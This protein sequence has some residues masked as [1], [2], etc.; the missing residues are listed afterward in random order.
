MKAPENRTIDVDVRDL[1]TR[2]R[3]VQGYAAVYGALSEDLGG[4]REKIAPGAFADVLDAD[5]RALLNHDPDQLLGRTKSG[6]LRLAEDPRGLRFE[7]DLP[8][9]P[10]GENV[11]AAVARQDLDG[12][13]FRF[14]VG[15]ESWDGDVRTVETVAEL[16]DV[17]LATHPAYPE[18]SVELRTRPQATDSERTDSPMNETITDE[19]PEV[20]EEAEERTAPALTTATLDKIS[21]TR[22]TSEKVTEAMLAVRP[23]ES[24]ALSN[25]DDLV[26]TELS[27]FLFDRLRES[28]TALA[29]GVQ[30]IQT[31]KAEVSFPRLVSDVAPSWF[32]E[33]DEITA[34]DPAFDTITAI[35][36]KLAARV[37]MSNEVIDDASPSVVE[38][39]QANLI[40]RLA[41]GLDDGILQGDGTGNAPVGLTNVDDTLGETAVGSINLDVIADGI[42]AIRAANANPGAIIL[43][44][45]LWTALQKLKDASDDRP[46][47][48]PDP[49]SGTRPSL[50]GVPVYASGVLADDEGESN[51]L[52]F[53]PSE[54]YL[55]RRSEVSVELDRSRLFDRDQSELR[56][57]LR[58]DLIVPN[59][60]AVWVGAGVTA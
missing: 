59:P 32:A 9:S 11:R 4:F 44:P 46:L 30:V 2:G 24:R 16:H 55:V 53:D 57:R 51:V 25:A 36:K 26:T 19:A 23:G 39:A 33:A 31:D 7:L 29:S 45:E 37:V 5:V 60:S 54:V 21:E 13:S 6:T 1:D 43:R 58:A 42:G 50:F 28:S 56:G 17:T 18:T 35:P 41:L 48:Q 15:S 3:T 52:V 12:A 47:L 22:S 20:V 49:T 14:L 38:V 8:D 10:V 40:T 34:S 27:T